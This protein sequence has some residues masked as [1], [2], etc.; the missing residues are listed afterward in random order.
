MTAW[1]DLPGGFATPQEAALA[2]FPA[3]YARVES[4]DYSTDGNEAK[5]ML[6]TNEEPYLY[7]YYV[8]CVRDSGGL[9]HETHGGN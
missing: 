2:D 1:D 7:R 5:V 4:V 6:L 8:W 3:R 9:W